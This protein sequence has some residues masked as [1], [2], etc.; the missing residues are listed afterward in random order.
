MVWAVI[1]REKKSQ[2]H[3]VYENT[4]GTKRGFNSTQYIDTLK[5]GLLPLYDGMRHFQQDGA[6]IHTA[7]ATE[8]FLLNHMVSILEWP[9]YSPDLNPIEHV[10]NLLKRRLF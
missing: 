10:W 8:K 4:P 1:S 6:S 7:K 5:K 9:P 2:L 3:I